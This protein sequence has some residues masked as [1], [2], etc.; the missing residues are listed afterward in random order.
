M[1]Y[2]ALCCVQHSPK[3]IKSWVMQK[4]EKDLTVNVSPLI[5]GRVCSGRRYKINQA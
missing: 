5:T 4:K 2:S 3:L 1:N